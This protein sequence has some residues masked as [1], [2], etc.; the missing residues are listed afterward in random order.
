MIIGP[1]WVPD[2]DVDPSQQMRQLERSGREA[3]SVLNEAIHQLHKPPPLADTSNQAPRQQAAQRPP[4]AKKMQVKRF[5]APDL[6]MLLTHLLPLGDRS[7]NA[8]K[9][10]WQPELEHE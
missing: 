6:R 10:L 3:V 8:T 2:A 7:A 5:L 4:V 1:R 9:Q